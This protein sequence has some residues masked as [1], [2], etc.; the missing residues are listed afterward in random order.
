MPPRKPTIAPP[1][2]TPT[3]STLA[4]TSDVDLIANIDPMFAADPAMA[5]QFKDL[6]RLSLATILDQF[7]NGS[8][9][10]K[11]R[12]ARE[13]G[14]LLFARK[15]KLEDGF[16]VDAAKAEVRMMLQSAGLEYFGDD[17]DDEFADVPAVEAR[18]GPIPFVPTGPAVATV[19]AV[20]PRPTPP[21]VTHTDAMQ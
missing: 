6:A 17:E 11:G 20:T 10:D 8:A 5:E 12:L 21:A 1:R 3:A 2:A 15:D 13:F 19:A 14:K 7:E 16:D 4:A 18:S 9:D